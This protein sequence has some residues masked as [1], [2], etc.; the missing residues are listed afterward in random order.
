M[1]KKNGIHRVDR[2][3]L[4]VILVLV[5]FGLVSLSSASVAIGYAK[6]QDIYF[7]V[8]RQL[9]FG[10]LPG[11]FL[12]WLC[13]RLNYQVWKKW[14]WPLYGLS[15]L[16]LLLIF[17]PGVGATINGSRSWLHLFGVSFQPSE[18]LKL[19]IVITLSHLL[20]GGKH[21]W[22]DWKNTLLPILGVISPG[23][24][25]VLLQPDIGTLSIISVIIFAMLYTAKV[26]WRQL[27]VLVAIGILAFAMVLVLS[28]RRAGR[29]TTFL[30]PELEAQG[31]GYQVNQAFLA[32]GT[33]GWWGLGLGHSRQK[34]QYLPEVN[35][36]SIYA[37]IAEENGFFV[38]TALIGMIFFIGARGFKIARGASD[39]FGTYLVTGFMVWFLW[40]SCLN[41]GAMVGAL[42][43]TGVPLPLVSH[44]GSA[45]VT[46]LMALAIVV[47]VSK[48]S[49][50]N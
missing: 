26:P 44:G 29:L 20:A 31:V 41:I 50:I 10:Y 35:A 5:L 34:F 2:T 21:D 8:K 16:L 13:S 42:P 12:F 45:V 33:G 37:I 32:V 39:E 24:L 27:G 23:V 38:S 48:T 47:N 6:Y 14:S 9:L 46:M 1:E 7:F 19:S 28:P 25:L 3:F 43:L 4:G 49:K 30:H 11:F 18:L 17:V 22:Q 36:D 40:Q 15:L